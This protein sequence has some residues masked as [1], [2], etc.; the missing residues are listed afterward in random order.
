MMNKFPVVVF[1]TGE[2]ENKDF[3][4]VE[5]KPALQTFC[6]LTALHP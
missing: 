5:G 6:A 3:S 2:K 4:K 1:H